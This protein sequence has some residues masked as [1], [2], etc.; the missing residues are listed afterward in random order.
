M[1]IVYYTSGVT[2]S[3]RLVRGL[4]IGNALRRAGSDADYALLSS[5]PFGRLADLLG[6]AHREIPPES[7]NQLSPDGYPDSAVYRA[8]QDL[9]PDILLVDLLWFPLLHF[10]HE[11]PG[12][13]VFLWQQLD[14]GFFTIPL[15]VG[16]LSFDPAQYDLV[17]AI[18]PFTGEG[19]ATQVNPLILR[20]RDEILP[21]ADALSA[22][23]L[24]ERK[25][26]LI[27][28]NA[29]P[30]DFE[31]VRERYSYLASSGYRLVYSTNYQGGLFPA[32]DYFN[33]FDLVVCGASYSAFWEA[34]YFDK[35][36]IFVPVVTRFTDSERLLRE[37]RDYRFE[38]NGADQLVRILLTL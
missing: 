21:R 22:L 7:E 34:V 18:E 32:V 38:E 29:H 17:V 36:A 27:A 8:L 16:P 11:I 2:G 14:A 5:S 6:F 1:R 19:P 28:I 23:D 25:H 33:A 24:T 12:R 4:S 10:L 13:K 35:E 3:G 26:C 37:Y 20:N 15:P 9:Q 31:R 30:G